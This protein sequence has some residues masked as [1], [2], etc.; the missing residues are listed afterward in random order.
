MKAG[1]D[2]ARSCE[3]AR[4]QIEGTDTRGRKMAVALREILQDQSTQQDKVKLVDIKQT[5]M[6]VGAYIRTWKSWHEQ[7]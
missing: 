1:V 2:K 6:E 7:L 4:F 5:I 3:A